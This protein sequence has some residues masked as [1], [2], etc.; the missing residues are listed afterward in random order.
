MNTPYW[1]Y[2]GF[3]GDSDSEESVCHVGDLGLIPGSGRSP[4][5][6]EWQPTPVFLPGIFHGQRSLAGYS[7]WGHK[8][9]DMTEQLTHTCM[10]VCTRAHTHTC[11]KFSIL[12]PE[13]YLMVLLVDSTCHHFFT[14]HWCSCFLFV[15]AIWSNQFCLLILKLTRH[16][17]WGIGCIYNSETQTNLNMRSIK[18]TKCITQLFQ[19]SRC[20]YNCPLFCH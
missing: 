17:P 20:V 2:W 15:W 11:S 19:V 13:K 14:K 7:S 10:H 4:G 6:R 18:C 8:E 5:G 16:I 3:A 1:L 9:S 12:K